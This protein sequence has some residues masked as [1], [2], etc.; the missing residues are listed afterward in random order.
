[1]KTSNI[2]VCN[3]NMDWYVIPKNKFKEWCDITDDSIV[4]KWA[5]EV[6]PSPSLVEFYDY[7]IQ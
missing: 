5:K 6:G 7:I 4:P 1:M 3:H 2:L